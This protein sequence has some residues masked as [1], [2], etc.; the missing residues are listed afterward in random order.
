M[1]VGLGHGTNGWGPPLQP[2]PRTP[3]RLSPLP[4]PGTTYPQFWRSMGINKGVPVA[5]TVLMGVAFLVLTTVVVLVTLFAG[6][7]P[8]GALDG[9]LEG[10]LTPTLV[11]AN[12]V[13]IALVLP[14]AFVIV[15]LMRQR[16]GFLSSV[17]GRFRWGLFWR[18]LGVTA[19]VYVAYTA[20]SVL[21][22]GV[23]SLGLALR[24][25]SW[26]LLVGLMLVTPFQAAAEEYLLRGYVLRTVGSWF[27]EPTVAVLVGGLVNSAIFAAL[28][29]SSDLWLNLV[30]FSMGAIGTYLALRTGGLEGAVA[31]HVVN[32]M[33]GMAFLPFQDMA[34]Q[35]DRTS[36]VG[37]PWVL[38][39]V[40]TF[41]VAAAL[42]VLV[43][44]RSGAEVVG[45][46]LAGPRQV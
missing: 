19:A 40:V 11:L 26:W 29:A 27:S 22:D 4:E 5:A 14:L 43:A 31:I 24:D 20:V 41:A 25:Y 9:V 45:P 36:G 16:P 2:L 44:R 23:D 12:S 10:T 32:N 42:I 46:P 18:F 1:T 15:R 8:M 7:D 3:Y 34:S 38:L 39:Q 6:P 13:A 35:F 37:G 28:H 21:I 30:Y 33:I 17:T